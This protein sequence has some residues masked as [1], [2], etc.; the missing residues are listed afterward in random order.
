LTFGGTDS[1]KFSGQLSYV[2][3]TGTSPASN[4]WGI[5]QT[6]TYG[7][8]TTLLTSSGIVDTGTTLLLIATG[9]PNIS[10]RDSKRYILPTDAFQAYQKATGATLDQLSNTSVLNF[11]S[12]TFSRTTGLLKVTQAQYDKLESLFFKIGDVNTFLS[13]PS[14]RLTCDHLGDL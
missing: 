14:S 6:L 10:L 5:D 8:N 1:S 12:L 2:P 11:I 7:N 13:C 4:Y 9:M 3:I